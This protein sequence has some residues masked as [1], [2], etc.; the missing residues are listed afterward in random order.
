MARFSPEV[1]TT[2]RH[3]YEETDK[4][5]PQIASERDVSA[6]TILRWSAEDGWKRR[7]EQLRGLPVATRL[8][9]EANALLAECG[10]AKNEAFTL[11]LEGEGRSSERSEDERGGV[12]SESSPPPAALR[13]S[14]SPLQGEVKEERAHALA[15]VAR[16]ERMEQLVEREMEIEE[17]ARAALGSLPRSRGDAQRSARTLSTLTQVLHA[18]V[19]LR[20]GLSPEAETNDN[21]DMPRDI[22]EFRRELARRIIAF[23]E[24]RRGDRP[25]QAGGDAGNVDAVP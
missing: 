5:I 7:S 11:P 1:R 2:V 16:I 8:R 6:R 18:L 21:D 17:T 3:D 9:D 14:T 15:H 13:A 12:K 24:S 25:A 20:S 23:V 4:P 22:D 19:R 10:H